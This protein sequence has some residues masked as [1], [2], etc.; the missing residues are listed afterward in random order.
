MVSIMKARVSHVLT[1]NIRAFPDQKTG[2][3]NNTVE[4]F[5]SFIEFKY[6]QIMTKIMQMGADDDEPASLYKLNYEVYGLS[7]P[8]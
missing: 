7:L 3:T 8:R 1:A 2:Q 4:R 5:M 6:P